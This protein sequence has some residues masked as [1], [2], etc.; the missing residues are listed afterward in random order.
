VDSQWVNAWVLSRDGFAQRILASRVSD[1][2]VEVGSAAGLSVNSRVWI[3]ADSDGTPLAEVYDASAVG[4]RR[5]TVPLPLA[6]VRGEANELQNGRFLNGL[7][8]W[9]AVN[10]TSPPAFAEIPRA[11][12]G[13]TRSGSAA[14]PLPALSAFENRIAAASAEAPSTANTIA[15]GRWAM[16]DAACAMRSENCERMASSFSR[17][18]A[19]IVRVAVDSS[20]SRAL[21]LVWMKMPQAYV[22]LLLKWMK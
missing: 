9:T 5:R 6:G 22:I 8:Q 7:D 14:A 1:G 10:P 3:A 2:A 20:K 17:F 16:R 13:V 15:T 11:E 12:M 4:P 18:G 19:P 21:A